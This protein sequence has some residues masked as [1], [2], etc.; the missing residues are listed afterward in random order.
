[1]EPVSASSLAWLWGIMA[2][3][4]AALLGL[5]AIMG[6]SLHAARHAR[7]ELSPE[8]L[9]IRADIYGR[10]IP[11]SSLVKGAAR[12]VDL[13]PGSGFRPRW[14]TNGMGLP[15][16]QSGWVRLANGERAL[17][18]LSDRSRAVYIPTRDGYALILSPADP[19]QFIAELKAM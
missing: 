7:F 10:L 14:R 17:V 6:W 2:V 3:T 8:G 4:V 11:E 18:F 9:R 15:G 1:M 13:A 19:D 12:R 5:T 16:Y